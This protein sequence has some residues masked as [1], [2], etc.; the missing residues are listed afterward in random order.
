MKEKD[1]QCKRNNERNGKDYKT[2]EKRI[3]LQ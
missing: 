2:E 1:R 3:K